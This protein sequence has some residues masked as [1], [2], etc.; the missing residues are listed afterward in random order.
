ML[1]NAKLNKAQTVSEA[2]IR[3]SAMLPKTSLLKM[4]NALRNV[5]EGLQNKGS[6]VW[7]GYQDYNTYKDE[8]KYK[9]SLFVEE[10]SRSSRTI[11]E[12]GCNTGE[13]SMI[14]AQQANFIVV[15][16]TATVSIPCV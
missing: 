10:F 9:K 4:I 3:K 1:L 15:I 8:D 5:I 12:L 2:N 13:Y 7:H 11:L 6:S 14:A 16:W